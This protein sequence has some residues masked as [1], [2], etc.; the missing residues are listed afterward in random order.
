MLGRELVEGGDVELYLGR[1]SR[2]RQP[3][4]SSGQTVRAVTARFGERLAEVADEC[5]HLAA[6]VLDERDDALDPLR[7]RLLAAVEALRQAVAQ[8]CERRR[9]VQQRE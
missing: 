4:G 5:L 2:L 6:V 9:P 8:L 3:A 1:R 7:L